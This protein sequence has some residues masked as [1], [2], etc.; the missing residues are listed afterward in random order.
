MMVDG[1]HGVPA[2]IAALATEPIRKQH[3]HRHAVAAARYG[4]RHA[5]LWVFRHVSEQ[6]GKLISADRC[7]LTSHDTY[8]HAAGKPQ[9]RR[10]WRNVLTKSRTRSQLGTSRSGGER[11]PKAAGRAAARLRRTQRAR[12]RV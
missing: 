2:A 7:S 4:E 6:S 8:A 11:A 12:G 3:H 10:E 9:H 1:E 5:R